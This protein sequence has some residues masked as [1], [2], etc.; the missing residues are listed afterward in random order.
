M[1]SHA[2]WI[3]QCTKHIHETNELGTCPFIGKLIVVY[4]DDSLIFIKSIDKNIDHILEVLNVL[5]ENKLYAN[6]K[7]CTFISDS[8]LFLLPL[9]N[10]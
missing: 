10:A 1:V 4:F 2:L 7:K 9:L 8:L 3:I 6:L 5:R